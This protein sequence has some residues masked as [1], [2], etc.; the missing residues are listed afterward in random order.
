M[1]DKPKNG[2][3]GNGSIVTMWIVR[4]LAVLVLALGG[5]ALSSIDRRVD[6]TTKT[7]QQHGE[8]I[9]ACE[10]EEKGTEGRLKRIEDK[11]DQMMLWLRPGGGP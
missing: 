6:A 4:T 11:I 8:R 7:V 5:W 3:G 10:T 9:T 2:N 1:S